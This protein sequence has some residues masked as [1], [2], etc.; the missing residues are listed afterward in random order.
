MACSD[1]LD[2]PLG[3]GAADVG[4]DAGVGRIY[5]LLSEEATGSGVLVSWAVALV[6]CWDWDAGNGSM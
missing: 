3:A 5:T 4:C 2:L 6:L 1:R